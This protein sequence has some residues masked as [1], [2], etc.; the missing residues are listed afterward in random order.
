MARTQT[1]HHGDLR[2]ALCRA[3]RDRLRKHGLQAL[4]LRAVAAAAGVSHAAPAHHFADLKALLSAVAADGFRTLAAALREDLR[5]GDQSARSRSPFQ[6]EQLDRFFAAYIAFARSE[7]ALFTL[8]FSPEKL[9]WTD[10]ELSVAARAA[11]AELADVAR[12]VGK[13]SRQFAGWRGD[14]VE[15]VIWSMAHGYAQLLIGGL[16]PK[17]GKPSPARIPD[18]AAILTGGGDELQRKAAPS[19]TVARKMRRAKGH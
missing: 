11:Y 2:S 15:Q 4:S 19:H 8:M 3:A 7:P 10:P 6:A 13:A 16:I 18:F 9:D 17:P 5:Q 14:D 1:Y 12:S